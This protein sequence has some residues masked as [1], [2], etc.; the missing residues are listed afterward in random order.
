MEKTKTK[1]D[2]P[3]ILD[4]EKTNG[5]YTKRTSFFL[6]R[7]WNSYLARL[8]KITDGKPQCCK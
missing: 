2:T 1:K 4:M 7:W 6:K 3:I 5:V 8:N